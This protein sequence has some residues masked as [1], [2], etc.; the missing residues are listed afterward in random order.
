MCIEAKQAKQELDA[1]KIGDDVFA[2]YVRPGRSVYLRGKVTDIIDGCTAYNTKTKK[3]TVKT[4][5]QRVG[6][7][8]FVAQN[9]TVARTIKNVIC[10]ARYKELLDARKENDDR[11]QKEQRKRDQESNRIARKHIS[12]IKRYLQKDDM[13]AAVRYLRSHASDLWTIRQIIRR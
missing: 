1:L 2:L 6:S 10:G 13:T 3:V 4:E 11:Y 12:A 9:I 8:D 7:Y 5:P